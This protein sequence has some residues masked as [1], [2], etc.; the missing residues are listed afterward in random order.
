MFYPY[1]RT[2]A[3]TT[4]RTV[5]WSRNPNQS[6][7][8][9]LNL[10]RSPCVAACL[11]PESTI[12][13]LV[14]GGTGYQVP[15]VCITN[16]PYSSDWLP[17]WRWDNFFRTCKTHILSYFDNAT[18]INTQFH[19]KSFARVL[20][21]ILMKDIGRWLPWM[22]LGQQDDFPQPFCSLIPYNPHKA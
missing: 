6:V 10:Y 16:Q 5:P 19:K 15:G 8:S 18:L 9:P 17:S 1:E 7:V 2:W 4:P 21:F 3:Y 13:K 20:C 11:A 14:P 22:L 12:P